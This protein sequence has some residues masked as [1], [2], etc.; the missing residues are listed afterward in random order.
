[1]RKTVLVTGAAGFIGSHLVKRY[2][3]LGD[4]VYGVDNFASSSKK[5]RHHEA[6][7]KR[8]GYHFLGLD[9]CSSEF[10]VAL[11]NVNFDVVYNFACPASPPKYQDMPIE[12]TLTCTVGTKNVLSLAGDSTVVVHAST[13]EVYGDPT[14]TPQNESY[15]GNVN[16]YGPRAC[17]DEGKRA[18][19]ALCYDYKNS[20]GKDVRLVRIFNTYGPQMDIQDGRVITNFVHQAL[21]GK[22]LTIYGNG[23][24]TRSFCYVSDLVAG[25]TKLASLDAN[26]GTP[27]NL[28]NPN[29][30]TILELAKKVQERFGC[31]LE[32]KSL[33]VD[34]P[35]QR[36]P[37]ISLAKR[38]LGW[39]PTIELDEGLDKTIAYFKETV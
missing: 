17:Y 1:M 37:D 35:L 15:R 38:L 32:F 18:A 22:P 3:D 28:G 2:L 21:S 25:I 11:S 33:P 4:V 30:F 13:S 26:P 36:R 24:Q 12:T 20:L 19:E 31:H 27:V 10:G 29:E 6:L 8:E 39:S 34:D 23:S 14:E 16:S 5:S 9:V 7:L